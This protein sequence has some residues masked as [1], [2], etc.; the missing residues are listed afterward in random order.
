MSTRSTHGLPSR[1]SGKR[2]V[3]LFPGQGD[4]SVTSLVRAVRTADVL[5]D[6]VGEVFGQLDDIAAEHDLPLLATRLLGSRPPS[7]RELAEAPAGTIQLATYG[8][9]L[10]V[11][12]ALSRV[13][14]PPAAVVGVSFGEIAAV[15][16]AGVLTVADGA[17]AALDLT[18]VLAF[19]PGGLTVLGCAA[20]HAARLLATAGAADTVVAVVN[21][22][23]T[24][25]VSGP[26]ADLVRVEK[27]A[28]ELGTS[29]VRLRLPFSSHRP[30]LAPQAEAFATLL[31]AYPWSRARC[32]V[33]SAV[34]QRSYRPD[35]DLRLGLADC[36]VKPAVVPTVLHQLHT[37]RPDLLLEAG[38]GDALATAARRVLDP[39]GGPPVHAPL[40]DPDFPW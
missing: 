11:H 33:F 5:R 36:L 18:R 16:A 37:C 34:A 2:P 14:G 9:S 19:C 12:R 13:Y 6:A 27:T 38:T 15:A 39:C 3:H 24:V 32:P 22:D 26:S 17:R 20:D 31:R 35:D 30:A 23:R 10:A 1:S 40:A 25:V 4:F 29:A 21:D 28:G 8:A 7:A